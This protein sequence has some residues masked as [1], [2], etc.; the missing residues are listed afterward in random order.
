MSADQSFYG[1]KDYFSSLR[2]VWLVENKQVVAITF[3]RNVW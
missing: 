1:T 3:R 2:D